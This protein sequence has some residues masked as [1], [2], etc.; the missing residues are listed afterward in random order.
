MKEDRMDDDERAALEAELV[1]VRRAIEVAYWKF[2]RCRR[3]GP[4]PGA[5]YVRRNWLASR[6]GVSA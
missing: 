5:L 6:L 3:A 4:V 1:E 2:T